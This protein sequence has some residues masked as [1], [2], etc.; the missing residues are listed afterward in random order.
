V[1]TPTETLPTKSREASLESA[2]LTRIPIVEAPGNGAQRHLER[3]RKFKRSLV[4][5]VL[6]LLVLTPTWVVTQYYI[7]DGWPKHLST[8]SRYAGDWDP[9]IIWV[10]L[11]GA[12]VVAIYGYRAHFDRTPSKDK[13]IERD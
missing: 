9:W 11:V 10:A 12:I 7:Q 1:P 2:E 3:V 8:R 4:I 5:Y 6:A 13:D